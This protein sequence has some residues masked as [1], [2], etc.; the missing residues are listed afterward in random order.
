M[1]DERSSVGTLRAV[2][3]SVVLLV[4]VHPFL[5]IFV[6]VHGML[7]FAS[8][9]VL[10]PSMLGLHDLADGRLIAELS[11]LGIVV[12]SAEI[13]LYLVVLPKVR[14]RLS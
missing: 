13:V 14:S 10:G 5:L 8:L 12:G 4:L 2:R 9:T 6:G 7:F 1:S 11:F 3:A